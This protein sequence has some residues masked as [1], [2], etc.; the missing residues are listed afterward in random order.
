VQEVVDAAIEL[1]RAFGYHGL[2]Q[3]EFKRDARDGSY[4]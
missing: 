1:L 3:V 4:S 2:S